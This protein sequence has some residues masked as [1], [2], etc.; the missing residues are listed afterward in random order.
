MKWLL[1]VLLFRISPEGGFSHYSTI[2][3]VYT[4]QGEC[5]AVGSNFRSVF[6]K[7]PEGVKSIS[8]CMPESAYREEGWKER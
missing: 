7:I 6:T 8:I 1:V 4:T 5:D 3:K 2:T